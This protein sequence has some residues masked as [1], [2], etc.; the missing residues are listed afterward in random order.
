MAATRELGFDLRAAREAEALT[1]RQLA[2][3]VGVSEDVLSH[4]ERGTRTPTIPN[5]FRIAA[6]FGQRVTAVWPWPE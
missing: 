1:V 2:A 6:H 3:I 4:A 5:R